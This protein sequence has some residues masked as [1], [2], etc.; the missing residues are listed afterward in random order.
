MLWFQ[1]G[2][3]GLGYYKLAASAAEVADPQHLQLPAPNTNAT[4]DEAAAVPQLDV[5]TG[6]TLKMD[7]LG[8]VV[9]NA[10]GSLARIANW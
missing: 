3:L 7:H 6:A 10:D 2:E 4:E 1:V 8:P 9:V 5:S